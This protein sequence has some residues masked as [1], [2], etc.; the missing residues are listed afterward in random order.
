MQSPLQNL[1]VLQGYI[2]LN[3]FLLFYRDSIS[4]DF[5]L[6]E[7][8]NTPLFHMALLSG[9]VNTNKPQSNKFFFFSS[10]QKHFKGCAHCDMKSF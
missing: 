8:T 6:E 9:Y 7:H 1:I 10:E 4:Y 3:E 2:F 5:Q